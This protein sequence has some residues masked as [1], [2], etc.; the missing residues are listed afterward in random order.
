[1]TITFEIDI[2]WKG[3][4]GEQFTAALAERAQAGVK[5]HVLI[6]ALG[7]QK[8]DPGVIERM[9]AAGAQVVL[10]NP[11]RWNTIARMNNRT[12]RKILVVDGTVGYTGGVG[13]GDERTRNSP[14]RAHWADN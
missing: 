10:Y 13:I 6:D 7:S 12:H 5:V 14:D 8:I 1:K 4:I 2:Y 11:V 9:R 3:S